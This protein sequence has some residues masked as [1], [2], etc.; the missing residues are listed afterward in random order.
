MEYSPVDEKKKSRLLLIVVCA[1]WAGAALY[2]YV[3]TRAPEKTV[4]SVALY[5]GNA[6]APVSLAPLVEEFQGRYPDIEI[7][8]LDRS[9]QELEGD[10]NPEKPKGRP[11]IPDIVI[12]NQKSLVSLSGDHFESLDSLLQNP[13]FTEFALEDSGGAPRWIMPLVSFMYP[14]Y[15]NIAVL[16]EAGFDHPPKTREEFLAYAEALSSVA[17]SGG[18]ELAAWTWAAGLDFFSEDQSALNVPALNDSLNFV[19]AMTGLLDMADFEKTESEKYDDFIAGRI[20]MMTASIAGTGYIKER[21]PD[22]EYSLTTVP[23]PAAY[24]GKPRFALGNWG[25]ALTKQSSRGEEAKLFIGFLSGAQANAFL[26]AALSGIPVNASARGT[27][28]E[29]RAQRGVQYDKALVILETGE[30]AGEFGLPP[31]GPVLENALR[32]AAGAIINGTKTPDEC[33]AALEN[34]WQGGAEN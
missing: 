32:E 19:Q 18:E 27:P 15:Y 28:P 7:T 14:L 6:E 16:R 8:I 3:Q 23:P 24:L 2:K 1:V 9:P 31:G 20:A 26:A 29:R 22:L 21:A 33:I 11:G 30:A 5:R 34:L 12:A 10:L 25:A 4:L 13:E 17:V